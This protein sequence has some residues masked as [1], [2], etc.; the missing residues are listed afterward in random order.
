[1]NEMVRVLAMTTRG[2]LWVCYGTICTRKVE[3]T[4]L[5]TAFVVEQKMSGRLS[6]RCY[7][8]DSVVVQAVT[9]NTA[10]SIMKVYIVRK[11]LARPGTFEVLRCTFTS[12]MV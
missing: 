1:M 6:G 11:G 2:I 8:A 3:M 12:V 7:V 10:A 4:I 9:A 5:L